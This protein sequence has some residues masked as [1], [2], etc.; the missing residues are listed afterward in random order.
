MTATLIDNNIRIDLSRPVSGTWQGRGFGRHFVWQ[1]RCSRGHT[2][3]VRCNAWRGFGKH[4]KPDTVPGA[5][6]CPQCDLD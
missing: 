4:R 3:N 1:Y 2:V 6:L 5:I